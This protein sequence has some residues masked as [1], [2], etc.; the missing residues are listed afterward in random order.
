[1]I[2]SLCTKF[3]THK[4]KAQVLARLYRISEYGHFGDAKH[5]NEKLSELRWKNG[6]R[7]YFTLIHNTEKQLVLLLV[8]GTKNSQKKDILKA[9]RSLVIIQRQRNEE[10]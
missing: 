3:R 4:T 9:K 7:I 8:G 5:L 6:L 1:M 2:G 10:V